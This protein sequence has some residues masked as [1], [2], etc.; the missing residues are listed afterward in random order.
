MHPW[1]TGT[2][3]LQQPAEGVLTQSLPEASIDACGGDPPPQSEHTGGPLMASLASPA[4]GGI[5]CTDARA[6]SAATT[7]LAAAATSD[8]ARRLT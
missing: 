1:W 2:G 5:M 6:P 8:P 7:G 3:G 4:R